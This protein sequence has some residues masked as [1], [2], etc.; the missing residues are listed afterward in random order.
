MTISLQ[1]ITS[2]LVHKTAALTYRSMH[3]I[4]TQTTDTTPPTTNWWNM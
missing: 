2:Y 1:L 3:R 4:N